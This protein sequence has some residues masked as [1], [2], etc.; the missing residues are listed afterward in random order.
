MKNKRSGSLGEDSAVGEDSVATGQRQTTCG[1]DSRLTES[2]SKESP[3]ITFVP[4]RY[5]AM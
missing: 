3:Q 5:L 2:I 4:P 1:Q